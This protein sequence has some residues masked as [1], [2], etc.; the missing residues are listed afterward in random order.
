M[1]MS[2]RRFT[3]LTN[4]F[5]KKVENLAHAVALHFTLAEGRGRG[6]GICRLVERELARFEAEEE[7]RAAREHWRR[8]EASPGRQ[9]SPPW[10][11]ASH[12]PASPH[13]RSPAFLLMRPSAPSIVRR[14]SRLRGRSEQ[15]PPAMD[16][17]FY[18]LN[19]DGGPVMVKD[20]SP[21]P[22]P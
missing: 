8:S 16:V 13:A 2:M 1:R 12:H 20:P 5:S 3:R 9:S 15:A 4:A 11:A 22:P 21:E 17:R 6:C 14:A 18:E 10:T 7:R 19:E